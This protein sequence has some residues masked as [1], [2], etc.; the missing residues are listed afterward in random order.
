[1]PGLNRRYEE[2]ISI[3]LYAVIARREE[4]FVYIAND[5]KAHYRRVELGILDGWQVQITDGLKVGDRVIIVGHRSLEDEQ[6]INI[7]R[8]VQD[9]AELKESR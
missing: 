7:Q 4:R 5:S 6:K 1:M 2:A 3:P 9:P 8:T